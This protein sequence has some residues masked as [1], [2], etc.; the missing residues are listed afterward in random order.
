MITSIILQDIKQLTNLSKENNGG[1]KAP[2]NANGQIISKTLFWK[3]MFLA[4]DEIGVRVSAWSV[5]I[6]IHTWKWNEVLYS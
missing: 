5:C 4:S 1:T 2:Q 3:F 6:A